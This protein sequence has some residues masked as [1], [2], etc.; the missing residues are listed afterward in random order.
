MDFESPES[1]AH[2]RSAHAKSIAT[3][4]I[5]LE[6]RQAAHEHGPDLPTLGIRTD[7]PARN[8]VTA[9]SDS[10]QVFNAPACTMFPAASCTTESKTAGPDRGGHAAQALPTRE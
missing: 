5:P 9:L 7:F 4:V 3:Q 1:C 10:G 2:F 6:G 8:L